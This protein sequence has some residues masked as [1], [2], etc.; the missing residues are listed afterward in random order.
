MSSIL[1]RTRDRKRKGARGTSPMS[2]T[3][4]SAVRSRDVPTRPRPRAWPASWKPRPSCGAAASSTQGGRLPRPRAP[5]LVRAPVRGCG[6]SLQRATPRPMPTCPA[7]G[8]PGSRRWSGVPAGNVAP[9][10][11]GMTRKVRASV[12][13]AVAAPFGRRTVADLTPSRVQ[14]AL[15]TL[16]AGGLSLETVNHHVRAVK[17][18]SRWLWRDGRAGSM[19]WPTCPPATRGRPPPGPPC[20]TTD[21]AGRLVQAAEHGP[22]VKGCPARTAPC[23]TVWHSGRGSGARSCGACPRIVPTGCQP[24]QDRLSGRLHEERQAGR[25]THRRGA[26]GPPAPLAGATARASRVRQLP[27]GR[28]RCSG[29]TS[30]RRHPVRDRHGGGRLPRPR[31]RLTSRISSPPVSR[32][33]RASPGTA[34]HP[35]VDNRGLRQGVPA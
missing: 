25:A 11:A 1:K 17:A 9:A 14:A 15:G 24:T 29:R 26:G 18:F 30:G 3:R 12:D 4:A 16:R 20:L 5:A 13:K 32:S 33:R 35:R 22:V 10:P 31:G 27:S 2:T 19:P 34:H 28:P 8:S 6:T 21:E 7:G 23:S